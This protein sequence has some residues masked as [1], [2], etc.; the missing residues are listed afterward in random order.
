MDTLKKSDALSFEAFA[1]QLVEGV[2][3]HLGESEARKVLSGLQKVY[4]M[5]SRQTQ[6]REGETFRKIKNL[7]FKRKET[8]MSQRNKEVYFLCVRGYYIPLG[9][10]PR[11]R[12]AEG[13]VNFVLTDP[14]EYA[15]SCRMGAECD[16]PHERYSV[17]ENRNGHRSHLEIWC[18]GDCAGAF[19]GWY[20]RA[21][22]RG[23]EINAPENIFKEE[24]DEVISPEYLGKAKNE[25]FRLLLFKINA[26]LHQMPVEQAIQ[27]RVCGY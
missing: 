12:R 26:E 23:S 2:L 1:E 9:Y 22:I 4:E 21:V 6:K 20:G 15:C 16:S 17:G 27:L 5:Q 10:N 3:A 19:T 14:K 18:S 7:I 25:E 13:I 8:A 11:G 24:G